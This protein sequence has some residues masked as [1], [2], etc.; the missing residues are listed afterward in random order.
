VMRQVLVDHAR[1]QGALKR[2]P[3]LQVELPERPGVGRAGCVAAGTGSGAGAVGAGD[4]RLV[5]LIEML[6]FAGMTA[7]ETAEATADGIGARGAARFCG[8]RRRG[9]GD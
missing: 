7:E 8:T 5:R 6:F 4:G 1:A 2:G 3:G 9:C